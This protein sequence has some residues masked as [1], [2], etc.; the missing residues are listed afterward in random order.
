MNT[1]KLQKAGEFIKKKPYLIWYSRN[2]KNLS[3]ESIFEAIINYGNWKDFI[4]LQKLFGTKTLY[5]LFKKAVS[6]KRSNIRSETKNYFKKYYFLTKYSI[7][8][9]FS[10]V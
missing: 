5:L 6:K 4:K 7:T 9:G 2:Y 3:E 8:S 10:K 1:S